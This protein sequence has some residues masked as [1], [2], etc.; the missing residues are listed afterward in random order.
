[1]SGLLG[2]LVLGTAGLALAVVGTAA[3]LVDPAATGARDPVGAAPSA[4]ARA[5]AGGDRPGPA[6]RRDPGRPTAL[7]MTAI[8]VDAP[9]V[10]LRLTGTALVP[11]PDPATLGW[12]ADGSAPGDGAGAV[13]VTGHNSTA[14]GAAMAALDE[15]AAGDEVVVA[16]AEGRAAY[17]VERVVELTRA[18][19]ADR[20]ARL[21]GGAGPERLVVVTCGGWDGAEWTTSTVVVAVP[22]TRS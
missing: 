2:R 9:V 20:A 19:L 11:P 15:A 6:A 3:W 5:A 7:R 22:L 16:T 8:G 1:M 17:V 4:V 21:L 14:G 18:E 13:V 12:W 10:P